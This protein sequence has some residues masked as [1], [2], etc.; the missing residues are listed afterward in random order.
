MKY[1]SLKKYSLL[2]KI[3]IGFIYI[4]ISSAFPLPLCI[5]LFKEKKKK[6]FNFFLIEKKKYLKFLKLPAKVSSFIK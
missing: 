6:P 3:L 5:C 2:S 1:V 4:Y